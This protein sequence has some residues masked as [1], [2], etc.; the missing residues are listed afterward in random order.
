MT[1]S[2]VAGIS[3]IRDNSRRILLAVLMLPF[4]LGA[5]YCEHQL[6]APRPLQIKATVTGE[7]LVAQING[8]AHETSIQARITLDFEDFSGAS[9][10][11]KRTIPTVGGLIVLKRPKNI[12]LVVEAPVLSFKVA[13]MV[14][15]GTT[16]KVALLYPTS[17]KKFL[18][19]TNDR[20]YGRVE[21]ASG[22][23]NA[24]V[25][26]AGA[27]ANIRPQHLTDAILMQPAETDSNSFYF[28]EQSKEVEP[29]PDLTHKKGSQVER[30]YYVVSLLE[31]DSD[32]AAHITRRVWF[33]RSVDNAP[34]TRQ[35][36]F[37][38]GEIV[39]DVTYSSFFEAAGHRLPKKIFVRRPIDNYSVTITIKP[40]SVQVDNNVPETAF[41]L[42]NDEGLPEINLDTQVRTP[43]SPKKPTGK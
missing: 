11:T 21:Q 6:P 27:L 4:L 8:Q 15:D 19:G 20:P 42:N 31:K 34:L 26:R 24:D 17:S 18:I 41:V 36:F 28:I 14:S 23:K 39:T 37:E 3:L 40:E 29:D 43:P 32:G 35:Q 7:N 22:S 30:P 10:G 38:N 16:F 2:P 5:S 33:D 25:Q 1:T 9:K 12:R 13:D